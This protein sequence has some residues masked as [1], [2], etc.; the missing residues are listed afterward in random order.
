[1]SGFHVRL[2][3]LFHPLFQSC[4]RSNTSPQTPD[5]LRSILHCVVFG[6]N[7]RRFLCGKSYKVCK[8]CRN[9]PSANFHSVFFP[10]Q[11]GERVSES[12]NKQTPKKAMRLE[13][14]LLVYSLRKY[15]LFY[16]SCVWKKISSWFPKP[17]YFTGWYF[18]LFCSRRSEYVLLIVFFRENRWSVVMMWKNPPTGGKGVCLFVIIFFPDEWYLVPGVSYYLYGR[19]RVDT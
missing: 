5:L 9:T 18:I 7:L 19:S 3:G 2:I 14:L 13:T 8:A 10:R 4:Q 6:L 12:T 17:I 15:I 1:M 11:N 16:Y